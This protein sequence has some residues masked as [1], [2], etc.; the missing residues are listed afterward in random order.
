[1]R[2]S[3]KHT[4][5]VPLAVHTWIVKWPMNGRVPAGTCMS[6][7]RSRVRCSAVQMR[8]H[9]ALTQ[10]E[11]SVGRIAGGINTWRMDGT[12]FLRLL[13]LRPK[14]KIAKTSSLQSLSVTSL[15]ALWHNV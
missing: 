9:P 8:L 10:I 15:D 11:K 14:K 7:S 4:H 2:P 3:L 6:N 1:M 12:K 13:Y 5:P